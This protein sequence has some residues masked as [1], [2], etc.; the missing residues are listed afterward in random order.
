VLRL[1]FL[2]DTLDRPGGIGRYSREVLAAL[3]RRSDVQVVV[4]SSPASETD[5]A[6]LAGSSLAAHVAIPQLG[7]AG[8]ALWE[9]HYSG[10]AFGHA[11]VDVVHSTKHL[12]PRVGCP[13]ILTVHD[14]LTIT[15]SHESNLMKRWLLPAQYRRSLQA[16]TA[17]V[18]VS[19]ATAAAIG[20]ERE[21]WTVKTT[22]IPNGVSAGLLTGPAAPVPAVAEDRFALI[23]GDL[24][25]RKNVTFLLDLWDRVAEATGLVL[26]VVGDGGPGSGPLRE[27]LQTLDR[28]GPVRWRPRLADPELRWCYEHAQVVLLSSL[29]EGFGL[30][31]VEARAFEAPVVASTAE[32]FVEV[33]GGAHD[34]VLVD[35][36]D[37]QAWFDAIAATT[38]VERPPPSAPSL[39]DGAI[40]WD[41]HTDR[42]LALARTLLGA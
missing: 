18:A 38:S 21:S 12:V 16:A 35:P 31:L 26:L 19:R 5:A 24:S 29:D 3:G 25:P 4:A 39:P 42:V 32:A 37:A 7:Q 34:V 9:R 23:V 10:I 15:R 13:T 41:E 2:A 1:G 28:R 8:I 14:M 33:S 20:R 30:P 6:L 36:R 40:S 11:D 27:R 17:L 22:V